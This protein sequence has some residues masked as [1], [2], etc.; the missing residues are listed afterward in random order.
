MVIVAIAPDLVTR[1]VENALDE[2][3][4]PKER[5]FTCI[6]LKSVHFLHDKTIVHRYD[7]PTERETVW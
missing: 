5:L 7:T 6:E 4:L 1:P 2:L 3:I